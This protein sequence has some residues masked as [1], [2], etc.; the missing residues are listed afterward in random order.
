[1]RLCLSVHGHLVGLL[2]REGAMDLCAYSAVLV[3]VLQRYLRVGVFANKTPAVVIVRFSCLGK[4]REFERCLSISTAKRLLLKRNYKINILNF[5]F[6]FIY[7]ICL[8]RVC[9]PGDS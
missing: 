1:L 6:R 5:P 9:F 7:S 8:Q 4:L 3:C 2:V